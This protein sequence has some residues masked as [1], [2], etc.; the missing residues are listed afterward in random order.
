MQRFNPAP[1]WPAAP[2]GWLPASD[3]RPDASWPPAPP[4]WSLVV[5]IPPPDHLS[6]ISLEATYLG[7]LPA[8]PERKDG[9]YAIDE[10]GCSFY[11][12]RLADQCYWTVPWERVADLRLEDGGSRASVA[13]IA[14]FG[15]L[16]LS[17]RRSST[18]VLTK[19]AEGEAAVWIDGIKLM[20]A[21][22]GAAGWLAWYGSWSKVT[23]APATAM[24]DIPAQLER[25]ADLH[26]Q[27]LLSDAEFAAGK[28]RILGM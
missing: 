27:G 28:A 17:A 3:W 20:N 13:T 7:G 12:G 15:V 9:R 2:A 11:V 10:G 5:E 21:T 18:L 6:G 23:P 8:F 4:G 26:R 16:G 25:L 19:T 22:A 24:A 1:G 14:M